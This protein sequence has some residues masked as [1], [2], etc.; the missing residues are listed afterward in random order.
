MYLYNTIG[1]GVGVGEEKYLKIMFFETVREKDQAKIGK[2]EVDSVRFFEGEEG[3]LCKGKK[4]VCTYIS[5]F[6]KS[7]TYVLSTSLIL[8]VRS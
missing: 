5:V 4:C 3:F 2:G 8:N 6:F 7:L 1:L